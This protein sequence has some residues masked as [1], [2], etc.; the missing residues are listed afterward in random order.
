MCGDVRCRYVGPLEG[1]GTKLA[2]GRGSGERM[3]DEVKYVDM[4]GIE[5]DQ[6]AVV[7]LGQGW[8]ES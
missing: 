1:G 3:D 8:G 5:E 4:E 7:R 2:H 6:M